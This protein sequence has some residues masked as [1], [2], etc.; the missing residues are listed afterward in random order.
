MTMKKKFLVSLV[1]A[2]VLFSPTA[3]H[4][5]PLGWDFAGGILQPLTTGRAAQIKGSYF[6]GTSTTA[7]TSAPILQAVSRF[8]GAGL[9]DCD[10]ATSALTWDISTW[11]FGCHTISGGGT[12]TA[13]YPVTLTGSAFGLAFSTT[14]AN[15]WSGL[16][17]FTN[18]GTTTF[19][20]GIDSPGANVNWIR[21][22]GRVI[23]SWRGLHNEIRVCSSTEANTAGCDYTADGT[24]DQVELLAAVSEANGY[25]GAKIELTKGIF[26]VNAT[27]TISTAK[28][29]DFGGAGWSTIIKIANGANK[30]AIAFDAP[31]EGVWASIHD[32][33]IEA[34]APNQTGSSGCLYLQGAIET[35]VDNVWCYQPYDWALVLSKDPD[36]SGYGH[37][38][39]ITRFHA[40]QGVDSAGNGGYIYLDQ[41]DENVISQSDAQYMGGTTRLWDEP[42]VDRAGLNSFTDITL[43]SN[44]GGYRFQ[45][46]SRSTVTGGYLDRNLGNQFVLKGTGLSV[47]G[48]HIYQPGY[49]SGSGSCNANVFYFDYYGQNSVKNTSVETSN[50]TGE[51]CRIFHSASVGPSPY[52]NILSNNN[53]IID[54]ALGGAADTF[55][56][57]AQDEVHGNIGVNIPDNIIR[58]LNVGGKVGVGTTTPYANL[59]V[60]ATTT[61]LGPIFELASTSSA[62]KY[63]TTSGTGFGTTTLSGLTVNG[64]AT[65]TANVGFNITT[66]CYAING[67]CVG[68]SSG[69]GI[70]AL[71]P[72]G[73]TQT[74][75]TQLFATSSSATNGLTPSLVITSTGGTHTFT[76]SIS[77]TLTVAGGGT[78]LTS[79]SDGRILMG[80]TATALT[81]LATTTGSVLSWSYTTGR[82]ISIATSTLNI[83]ISD[84]TGV[85]AETRGGTN[86]SSY[87]TGDLL[88]ASG[89]NTLAK[90][91]IG[92]GGFVLSVANGVPTWVAT[93]TFSTGLTYTAG[94]VT[95]NTTQ[96]ITNLSNLTSNALV[97]T[98]G[99]N[100]TLGAYA[101]VTCTNQFL[102]ALSAAGASTCATVGAAD[103]SLANL[104][105]T[106]STLTF[107]GTYTGATARTIGL[108]LTNANTWTG[109]QTFGNSTTTGTLA[110]PVGASVITPIAGNIAI[111]TTTG[112][113]RYS[114]VTGTSRVLPGYFNVVAGYATTT[115]TG[116]T[117]QLIAP[118]PAN[119]TVVSARCETTV[120]TVG[121]SLYDGTNRATYMPTASTTINTFTFSTNNTFTAG[122][123]MRVDFGT[124]ASSPTQIAC[125]FKY[126]YDAD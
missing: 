64:S 85:L 67:T 106:D 51:T 20:G 19:T 119:I 12:Y 68:G 101:G 102:R 122:E 75:A 5:T 82:P 97:V 113:L 80:S 18:T 73:Q 2:F 124:P 27:T 7:T 123:T 103:V 84:T 95:V 99:G 96:N 59:A 15:I 93:T 89:S 13:T 39:V 76:S 1:A 6:T 40:D 29:I 61:Q 56:T 66:G 116:T 88:Y 60:Q 42:I 69:T 94:A 36:M 34:N 14:T 57:H 105:A 125:R 10:A 50:T 11:T 49:G 120:G 23:N 112:Q 53:V 108:N 104:T 90:R 38:N 52:G 81:S 62:T 48:T 8:L 3:A 121:V 79:V 46:A 92:T 43:V 32:F 100:G 87:S 33:K 110:I 91:A 118:A 44:K 111:D 117:T 83:A 77:G 98:S 71:G 35:R 37:N 41:N 28:G 74:A 22:A 24:G 45:D 21:L 65:S 72:A 31:A 58:G 30:Y 17:T 54:G 70:T 55:A 107:S 25:G 9:S 114:D 16:Q 115:W 4:A 26:N 63:L 47:D 86:Q 109:G 78:G 126:T